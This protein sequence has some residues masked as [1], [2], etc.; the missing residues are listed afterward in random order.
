MSPFPFL[1]VA[2]GALAVSGCIQSL[3]GATLLRRFCKQER[4]PV[5]LNPL[6]PV[7][8]L[9]PLYGDEPLL[10]EALES[11]C[12]QNYPHLQILFGVRDDNDAAIGIVHRLQQRHPHLDMQI[13]VNPVVHG[14]NRKISNLMN[15]L[16]YAKHDIL[17]ISDSDIHVRPDY[18]LHIVSALH[19]PRTGLVTTLYAGLP[20]APTL[21]QMLAACQINHNFL[22]GVILSRYLGRQD[23][24]GATMALTRDML[25]A[26]GGLEA[27]L[28]HVADDAVLG[29]L[30][31][32]Q[33]YDITIADCLT[34]TTIAERNASELLS[35]EL[36]WGRTVCTL[37]PAGYAASSIQLPL[38]WAS[39]AFLFQPHAL[40]AC[41]LFFGV[42][43]LRMVTALIVDRTVGIRFVWPL[44]LLPVRDWLSAAIM[45]GSASGTRVDWRGETMHVAPHPVP[46]PSPGHLSPES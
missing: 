46:P 22:P 12:T 6:P 14:M 2:S 37:A 10:E 30:V 1:A 39:L 41:L 5:T 34:W 7:T 23:C 42:W 26:V 33:G 8:V 20:S 38:F 24:L 17:V 27:L 11:F 21:V 29:R 36:R 15:I 25:Q 40:W 45:V 28:P 16:P 9:K 18:L 43:G 19:K 35:H 13:V 4:K 31:R 44:L 3:A 32:Q